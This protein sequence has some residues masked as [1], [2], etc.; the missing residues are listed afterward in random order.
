MEGILNGILE[1]IF[2]RRWRAAAVLVGVVESEISATR[3]ASAKQGLRAAIVMRKEWRVYIFRKLRCPK[4]YGRDEED[5]MLL[6]VFIGF[7]LE[8]IK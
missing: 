7:K 2:W 4:M 1:G 6:W 8:R 3:R 5:N